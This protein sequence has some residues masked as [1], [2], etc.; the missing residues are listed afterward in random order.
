MRRLVRTIRRLL[1]ATLLG[2]VAAAA[3]AHTPETTVEVVHALNASLDGTNIEGPLVAGAD[4]L[5]YGTAVSGGKRDKGTVF[6][7]LPD[8]QLE[9]LHHFRGGPDDGAIPRGLVRGPDGD[10]YGLTKSGGTFNDGTAFRVGANGKVTFLHSFQYE[11][12]GRYP[13]GRLALA[14]DGR[15]YGV[16]ED[17]GQG[18]AGTVF[19]MRPHGKVRTLHSFAFAGG[20]GRH[21]HAGLVEGSDGQLYGTTNSG[22]ALEHG[23]IF[24]V[25]RHGRVR[26]LHDFGRDDRDGAILQGLTRGPDD[27]LYG[28]VHA[29]SEDHPRGLV[30]RIDAQGHYVVFHSFARPVEVNGKHPFRELLLGRDGAFYGTTTGGGAFNH[31]TVFRLGLD[32]TL[33]TLHSFSSVGAVGW[34]AA[35]TLVEAGDGVFLGAT[36]YGGPN[37]DGTVYRLSAA[38]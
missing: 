15:F 27:R 25:S 16:T 9:V 5:F 30:Y 37:Q 1:A 12:D 11:V 28:V 17:G 10:L 23:T 29:D 24:K 18:R 3:P 19:R 6:R 31:G 7:L 34:F 20:G 32:G 2:A 14:G 21:P 8:G 38:P 35:N 33:T 36:V 26:I 13:T 22:G 4:G